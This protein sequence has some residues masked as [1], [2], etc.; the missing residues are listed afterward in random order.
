MKRVVLVLVIL[1]FVIA[2]NATHIAGGELFY[3][4]YNKIIEPVCKILDLYPLSF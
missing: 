4:F 1:L 3:E 2:S